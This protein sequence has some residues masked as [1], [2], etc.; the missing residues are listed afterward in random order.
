MSQKV[1]IQNPKAL[2][3]SL[4][5]VLMFSVMNGT[6]FNIAIPDIAEA[7]QLMPSEVS[8]VM[9]GYI[10]VYAV[11]ALVYGKLTDT[12]ALKSLITFGL[13]VFSFGSLLGFMAPN[14]GVVLLAR[15]IQA[16]GGSMIPAIAFIAPIRYFP[17]ERGK[18]LGIISSVMA[19]ASG[20][21][22][23]LGGV[24]G[25]FLSWQYLFLTSAFI[26]ITLPFLRANLPDESTK[27]F[28]LDYLGGALVAGLI[29]TSL[30]GITL[31]QLWTFGIALLLLILVALR[32]KFAKDPFIPPRL[33]KNRNYVVTLV[34]SFIGVAC[35]FGLM[36]SVPIMLRDVYELTTLQI[37]LAMFPGAMGAALIG[38]KGGQ[39]VDQKGSRTIFLVSLLLLLTGFLI[40]S[41]T[42]GAHPVIFSLSL[43]FPMLCFP[44]V[45]S[46]GAD[47]LAGIL[48]QKETGIGMGVFNLLNFVS[49]A[50]SGALVGKVLDIYRPETP[51][52]P[53]GVVGT[54]A[55]YSNIF[56]TF[57]ILILL[58]FILFKSL[59]IQ[60]LKQVN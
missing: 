38:R 41:T 23:I 36:F 34:V 44:L 43:I 2:L 35:L 22:P 37:G 17:N 5:F 1:E 9:T 16:I 6:M 46:S 57:M 7:F 39:L 15:I 24:I 54:G 11:G 12:I 40:V 13:V 33:F 56:I 20:I 58:G 60:S 49:G 31:G 53:F 32:M 25:G 48:S 14:Y 3:F 18:I 42:V 21:G 45:Q 19:F 29:V 51:L 4:C 47:I 8:W 28:K 50:L 27:F 52:N 10:M 55:V 26:I 30:M 59:H